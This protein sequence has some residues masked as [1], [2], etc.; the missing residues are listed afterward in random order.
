MLESSLYFSSENEDNYKDIEYESVNNYKDI[1]LKYKKN[2][3][4][5]EEA[6]S[7]MFKSKIR[8]NQGDEENED[9]KVER[10]TKKIMRK[11]KLKIDG[12]FDEIKRKYNNITKEDAYIICSYTCEIEGERQ[13]N[14]YSI[15]NKNLVS[16]N[17]KDGVKKISKYVY[18]LLKSLRKLPRYYPKLKKLYRC[19][20]RLVSLS[21]D[22]FNKKLV[23]YKIGNM[24]KLW[25]FT[26]TSLNPI[27]S[28]DFLKDEEYEF[29]SGE[30]YEFKSGTVFTYQGDNLWGYNI[31][32]FSYYYPKE[33]EVLIEPERK[34]FVDNVLPPQNGIIN[35]TCTIIDSPLILQNI[36][37]YN[38][39][40]EE[41]KK[42]NNRYKSS[43]LFNNGIR[44]RK[45]EKNRFDYVSRNNRPR[46]LKI[47]RNII[48]EEDNEINEIKVEERN[49]RNINIIKDI[50]N[51]L[52]INKDNKL[53]FSSKFTNNLTLEENNNKNR[54]RNKKMA[55]NTSSYNERGRNN[56]I[57]EIDNN[58]DLIRK[59]YDRRFAEIIERNFYDNKDKNN[60][61]RNRNNQSNKF[62]TIEENINK[63]INALNNLGYKVN[64]EDKILNKVMEMSKFVK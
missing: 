28:Y 27:S 19:I 11:C 48:K 62:D 64:I 37:P 46:Q 60:A 8:E 26:S 2:V 59:S 61:K 30:E 5:L 44:P 52:N 12:R 4:S 33:E 40:L 49:K 55:R 6:L 3:P 1:F 34:I 10:L 43:N 9:E 16:D 24:K 50:E 21:D 22:P 13:Y 39:E 14:P 56:K 41:E 35:V 53:S 47:E 7:Q 51:D 32:L 17:R 36:I 15:M 38:E 18:L 54:G 20:G 58:N 31:N 45:E 29:K 42:E 25:A 63:N 23:P 57:S